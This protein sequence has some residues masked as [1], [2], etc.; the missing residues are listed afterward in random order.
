MWHGQQFLL[1][2]ICL[3]L[4]SLKALR[5]DSWAQSLYMWPGLKGEWSVSI[6]V[7]DLWYYY[8]VPRWTFL[9]LVFYGLVNRGIYFWM[10]S[11][12]VGQTLCWEGLN[13]LWGFIPKIVATIDIRRTW[14][15]HRHLVLR[16]GK[17]TLDQCSLPLSTCTNFK[18]IDGQIPRN[19][20]TSEIYF[21]NKIWLLTCYSMYPQN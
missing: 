4:S 5:L 13:S 8:T 19:G 10:E 20:L 11:M 9:P 2:L 6:H 3:R 18:Y 15:Q 16:I 21:S 14:E 1:K 7:D 12:D 17:R